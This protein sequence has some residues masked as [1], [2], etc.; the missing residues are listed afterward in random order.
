[1]TGDRAI[2]ADA[3]LRL[4]VFERDGHRCVSCGSTARL[5]CDHVIPWSMGG[6]TTLDNLQTL[7]HPCNSS[8]GNLLPDE[9]AVHL[10]AKHG[11][12][13]PPVPQYQVIRIARDGIETRGAWI[14]KTLRD[15][16]CPTMGIGPRRWRR[17]GDR[18]WVCD[19]PGVDG[20]T[21]AVERIA[22]LPA[23]AGYEPPAVA[24]AGPR[25]AR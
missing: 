23:E 14:R 17:V 5:Q 12:P 9:W 1:M 24:T 18:K 19:D 25:W 11:L 3:K 7:C 6:T 21:F 16:M 15:A 2:F 10:A 13:R 8:K 4:A 22:D 20:E